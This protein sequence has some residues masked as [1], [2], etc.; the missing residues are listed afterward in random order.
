VVLAHSVQPIGMALR[1]VG[2]LTDI[3]GK[4]EE[5]LPLA[6]PQILPVP[7]ADR[8]LVV[9]AVSPEQPARGRG[10]PG[11]AGNRSRPSAPT[12]SSG[13]L[14]AATRV[15]GQSIDIATCS[16]ADPAGR[17][18]GQRTI[19]GTRDPPSSS[20]PLAP[21]NGPTSEN[22]SPPLSLVKTTRVLCDSSS[23]SS[24][25]STRPTAASMA[26]TIAP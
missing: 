1:Q 15:P 10:F 22:R 12:L 17:C 13:T 9:S 7:V 20:S 25:A 6:D 4:I 3:R 19:A 18:A 24:A 2:P 26:A 21:M 8:G 16:H 14:A 5:M 11:R 23:A